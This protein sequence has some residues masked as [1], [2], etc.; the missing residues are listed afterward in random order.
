MST[1]HV[2]VPVPGLSWAPCRS[3]AV[4]DAGLR[5]KPEPRAGLRGAG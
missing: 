3:K 1:Q 5:L 4:A 2:H